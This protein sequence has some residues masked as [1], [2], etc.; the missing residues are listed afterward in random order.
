MFKLTATVLFCT[1]M[2][3]AVSVGF[4]SEKVSIGTYN[5][6]LIWEE[7]L[8]VPVFTVS[9]EPFSGFHLN[10]CYGFRWETETDDR[11]Y[12]DDIHSR[13]DTFGFSAFYTF[14]S[15]GNAR[16]SGGARFQHSETTM[17]EDDS[18][19]YKC[20][21]N[22]YGPSARVDF[23]IPGLEEIGFYSQWGVDYKEIKSN[24]D[25]IEEGGDHEYERNGWTTSGPQYVL[26]GIYYSF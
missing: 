25:Y 9:V 19:E 13:T 16:F 11:S 18:E 23:T 3:S 8:D 10:G 15:T 26:S 14:L 17:A 12:T 20:T 24:S 21:S 4:S 1:A 2:S 5:S 6:F 7:S 22:C